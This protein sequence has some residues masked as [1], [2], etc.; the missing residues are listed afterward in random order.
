MKIPREQIETRKIA[1]KTESGSPVV[2]IATKGGLHAF[3]AKNG[4]GQ[5]EAL[6][7]APHRAIAKFLAEKKDP[8]IKWEDD[9]L[10]KSED[11]A[12]SEGD[13]FMK[14]RKMILMPCVDVGVKPEEIYLVYDTV[15]KNIEIIKKTDLIESLEKGEHD[16]YSLIRDAC[17]TSPASIIKDH[18]DFSKFFKE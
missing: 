11:L 8:K 17:L 16:S 12:K 4:E 5:T 7:A 13:L 6:G 3:F 10:E 9:F 1:G 14:L 2:Y 15:E 18:D